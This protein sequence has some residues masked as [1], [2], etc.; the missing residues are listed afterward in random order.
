M[1]DL[2]TALRECLEKLR[3]ERRALL[4]LVQRLDDEEASHHPHGEWSVKQQ[5][6]HLGLAE[7]AWLEWALFVREHPGEPFG[8]E[9]PQQQ[10]FPPPEDADRYP[11]RHW[12][13]HLKAVRW[14]TLHRL[15]S[16]GLTEEDLRKT[17]RHR[18]FGEMS[19]LQCLRALYRHDRMHRDQIQG[20]PPSFVPGARSGQHLPTPTPDQEAQR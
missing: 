7:Q 11:L 18:A 8:Q 14:A 9:D 1:Q 17:G 13:T 19:V 2:P 20:R 16:A 12:I 6:A 3:Q 5:L 4:D 15:R 10:P